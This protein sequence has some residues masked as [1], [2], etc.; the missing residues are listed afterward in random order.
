MNRAISQFGV[1][2]ESA[3]QLG[4]IHQAF[5]DKVTGAIRL[6]EL[7]RAEI[8]LA[9]SALD[10]YVHDVVRI[11]MTEILALSSGESTAFLNFDVSLAFVK[12]AL[13]APS[14]ADQ[15][16]L[17]EQEVRRLHGFRTFQ[18]AEKALSANIP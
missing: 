3:K 13:R 11:R 8:V 1:N 15:A 9:V 7:L 10:C 18:R 5:V 16:A 17:F 6:D 2:L 14:A 4:V 12:K